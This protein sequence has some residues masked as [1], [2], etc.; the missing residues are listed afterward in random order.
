[1]CN[2]GTADKDRP[3]SSLQLHRIKT[4]FLFLTKM[5]SGLRKRGTVSYQ[6]D[7]KLCQT[8]SLQR[9]AA[10]TDTWKNANTSKN[11]LHRVWTFEL[12]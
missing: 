10:I 8:M 5:Q 3:V 2:P 12:E 4:R 1:M 7:M 6:L 11:Q 9:P